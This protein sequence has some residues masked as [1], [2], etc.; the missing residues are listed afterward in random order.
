[1]WVCT[2]SAARTND[3]PDIISGCCVKNFDFCSSLKNSIIKSLTIES[4]RRFRNFSIVLITGMRFSGALI[5]FERLVFEYISSTSWL[6]SS[7]LFPEPILN[8]RILK[9]VSIIDTFE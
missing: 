8:R 1:M 7:S 2:Q 6:F 4:G 5:N 9:A 3:S